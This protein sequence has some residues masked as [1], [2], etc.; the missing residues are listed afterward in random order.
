[1][2]VQSFYIMGQRFVAWGLGVSMESAPVCIVWIG[3]ATVMI[4]ECDKDQGCFHSVLRVAPLYA[5]LQGLDQDRVGDRLGFS[6]LDLRGHD[7]TS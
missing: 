5:F 3:G 2:H 7:A 1:M 6:V 4:S